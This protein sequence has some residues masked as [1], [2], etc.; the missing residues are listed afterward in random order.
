MANAG[1]ELSS[2]WIPYADTSF[3]EANFTDLMENSDIAV[4]M[5]GNWYARYSTPH[6]NN[7]VKAT[8]EELKNQ[9]MSRGLGVDA[10]AARVKAQLSLQALKLAL[11]E[12]ATRY[13]TRPRSELVNK[14]LKADGLEGYSALL[15]MIAR[16]PA[17]VMKGKKIVVRSP[18]VFG[19][20]YVHEEAG[21]L[22]NDF[23]DFN[24]ILLSMQQ[25]TEG[26]IKSNTELIHSGYLTKGNVRYLD[27]SSYSYNATSGLRT[28]CPLFT[29]AKENCA[30]HM[31]DELGWR[32]MNQQL[33]NALC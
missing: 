24:K 8:L 5:A 3:S 7:S 27:S 30:C 15:S 13:E 29:A 31:A 9:T 33:L 11:R 19:N 25:I 2:R 1:V 26:A 10:H 14:K 32:S 20:P 12:E 21:S 6:Y 17:D 28:S 23:H 22:H 18:P 4:V 16:Q